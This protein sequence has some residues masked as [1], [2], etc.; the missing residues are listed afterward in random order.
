MVPEIY[1][2][3]LWTSIGGIMFCLIIMK[4][5]DIEGWLAVVI[6]ILC[7]PIAWLL[8]I[9]AALYNSGRDDE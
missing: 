8:F 3:A 4:E 7:G 1:H 2:L 5:L 9:E 6:T